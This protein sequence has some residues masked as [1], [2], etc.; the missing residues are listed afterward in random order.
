LVRS[1]SVCSKVQLGANASHQGRGFILSICSYLWAMLALA[2]PVYSEDAPREKTPNQQPPAQALTFANL[3][4][5]KIT[6]KLVTE[7]LVQRDGFQGPA[8]QDTDWSITIGPEEKIDWT[9]QPTTHSRVGDRAG[10]KFTTTATLDKSWHTPNGEAIWQF[11]DGTLVFVRSYKNAGAYRMS[12]ALKQD[13]QNLA[14][15]VA[16][17]FARERGKDNITMN[18]AID[19][20]PVTIFSWKTL[21]STCAA[22]R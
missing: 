22:A 19:G 4:G 17:T 21:S 11:A 9:F 2:G 6:I 1:Q 12:I 20:A 18:S 14:C 7:M 16:S 13:G 15:S 10:Q 8:T 3:E 5:V